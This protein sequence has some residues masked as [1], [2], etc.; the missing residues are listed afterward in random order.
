MLHLRYFLK[1]LLNRIS[2]TQ[3]LEKKRENVLIR[4]MEINNVL[5]FV[6]SFHWNF[7]VVY[8]EPPL[9]T[10]SPPMRVQACAQRNGRELSGQKLCGITVHAETEQ[11]RMKK[12]SRYCRTRSRRRKQKHPTRNTRKRKL[13][14]FSFVNETFSSNTQVGPSGTLLTSVLPSLVFVYIC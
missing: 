1:N 14:S 4:N 6:L 10:F 9:L 8:E 7:L 5:N 11:R 3:N 12:D 2:R 13:Q